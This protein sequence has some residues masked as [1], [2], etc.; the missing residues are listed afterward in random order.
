M[1]IKYMC[2]DNMRSMVEKL[3]EDNGLL[4]EKVKTHYLGRR[5]KVDSL[6]KL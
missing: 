3:C 2:Q 4:Y 1:V 6:K 5:D